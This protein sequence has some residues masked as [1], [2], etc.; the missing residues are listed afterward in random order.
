LTGMS[1]CHDEWYVKEFV[2]FRG[3]W[4]EADQ[5]FMKSCVAQVL[6]RKKPGAWQ[7]EPATER[8]VSYLRA[9]GYRGAIPKTKGEAG[10]L[11][12]KYRTKSDLPTFPRIRIAS[13]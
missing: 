2:P 7:D 11:I 13:E 9:L 12:A 1:V 4:I 5:Q 3:E 6:G 8:Q 10:T